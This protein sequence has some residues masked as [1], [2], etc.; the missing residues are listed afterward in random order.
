MGV[1]V[2]TDAP[3]Y[4]QILTHLNALTG[5]SYRHTT[6]GYRR[7][8]REIWRKLPEL[9]SISSKGRMRM[10]ELVHEVKAEQ[11]KGDPKMSHL[12]RPPTLYL[13]FE[14]FETYL[15]EHPNYVEWQRQR[16][17]RAEAS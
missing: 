12:L 13:N 17:D 9:G 1:A 2:A 6:E 8:I 7:K 10:F 16:G 4:E 15:N 5:K 11:W 14:R 3:P